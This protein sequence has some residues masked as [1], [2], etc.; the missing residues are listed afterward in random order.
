MGKRHIDWLNEILGRIDSKINFSFYE[1]TE[2]GPRIFLDCWI[3]TMGANRTPSNEPPFKWEVQVHT[4][5]EAF[6]EAASHVDQF[7]AQDN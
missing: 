7:H 4:L 5:A 2:M 3:C 6:R 1:D